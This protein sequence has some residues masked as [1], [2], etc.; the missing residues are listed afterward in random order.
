MLR[1]L[2]YVVLALLGLAIS[3]AAWAITTNVTITSGGKPLPGTKISLTVHEP[4]KPPHTVTTHTSKQGKI[5]VET[6]ET[7]AEGTTVDV[8][9]SGGGTVTV[10]L[11]QLTGGGTLE[12]GTPGSTPTWIPDLP[13][14]GISTGITGTKCPDV[15]TIEVISLGN[16][17]DV[18]PDNT[19]CFSSAFRGSIYAGV[20]RMLNDRWL[21]GFEVDVGLSAH[22]KT[23]A[24]IP[25]LPIFFPPAVSANDSTRLKQDW[26]FGLRT[27][28]GYIVAPNWMVFATG[29][30]AFTNVKLT[31]NCTAAGACGLFGLTPFTASHSRVMAG[32]R[33]RP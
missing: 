29:G 1:K 12:V 25:G 8:T 33:S 7:H 26:D 2:L 11:S 10:P 16:P 32:W 15:R 19:A 24:G 28:L 18:G 21:A 22:D 14:I 9:V 4:G 3:S 13:Y 17:D 27:R 20:S 6:K 23:Q 30:V 31:V 5:H